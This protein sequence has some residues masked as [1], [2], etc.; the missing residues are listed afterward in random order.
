MSCHNPF[1]VVWKWERKALEDYITS[2][3]QPSTTKTSKEKPSVVEKACAS[4]IFSPIS[5]S[6]DVNWK[7]ISAMNVSHIIKNLAKSNKSY[8]VFTTNF[9]QIVVLQTWECYQKHKRLTKNIS[10]SNYNDSLY[11]DELLLQATNYFSFSFRTTSK[12]YSI[13][14]DKSA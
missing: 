7:V 13:K 9:L 11:Y 1:N 12:K 14:K 6:K 2:I 8:S 5:E 4:W 3:T 10:S